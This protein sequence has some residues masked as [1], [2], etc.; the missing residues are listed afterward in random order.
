MKPPSS[1]PPAR[2]PSWL[3]LVL[4]VLVALGLRVSG[5]TTAGPFVDEGANILSALDPRVAKSFEPLAQGRPW[6]AYLFR[7]AGWFSADILAAA[8]LMTVGAGLATML[9]LGWTLQQLS[10]RRAALLGLWLWA[11]LPFAVFH[12]RLA[13]Q[14]PFVTL[15]LASSLGL[16]ARGLD[17]KANRTWPWF[18]AAGLAFGSAFMLKISA[19]VALPWI[20][21]VYLGMRLHP[22]RAVR[23]RRL[24]LVAL[25]AALPVLTLGSSLA[26]LGSGLNRYGALPAFGAS[27]YL[28]S[29]FERAKTWLAWHAGYSSWPLALLLILALVL[30]ARSRNRLAAA[31]LLAAA[32]AFVTS[33][34]AYNNLYARY[35]LP[36]YLPMVLG[37]ALALGPTLDLTARLGRW[38]VVLAALCV[39]AWGFVSWTVHTNSERARIPAADIAQYY[40]GPW[41][42]RG[43]NDLVQ[44]L[45]H[46]AD[47]HG[48]R[49]VVLTHRFLRPGA[50]GLLLAERGDARLGVLPFTI[51]EPEELAAAFPALRQAGGGK[52]VEYFLLYEGSLFPARPWLDRPDAP[53]RRLHEIDRG[54]G[55][56]FVLYRLTLP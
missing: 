54:D 33:S 31:C 36:D 39:A 28:A 35:L 2:A 12:E 50:Y 11:V 24:L 44:Y 22:G 45:T 3:W 37:I 19:A 34:L 5:L 52:P 48:V 51:Y 16:L 46:Y 38:L 4:P 30:T 25:G 17:S 42:G 15:L 18:I 47:D 56:K 23:D 55:E 40:T 8:R 14:D 32:V 41:S 13:L 10:G 6:V 9:V 26:Q 1:A 29:V 43:V 49:C 20:A 7:P 21:V 53:T 27:G